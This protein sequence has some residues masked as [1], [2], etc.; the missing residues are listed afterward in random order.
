MRTFDRFFREY[1]CEKINETK[2]RESSMS[3]NDLT[4]FHD[5]LIL[6]I[7]MDTNTTK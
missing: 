3:F 5:E 2:E 4:E 6:H 7:V 1:V